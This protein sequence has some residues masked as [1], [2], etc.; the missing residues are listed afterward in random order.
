MVLQSSFDDF[1]FNTLAAVSGLL[2]KLDY[3]AGL[4]EQDGTY[5]HW[6]LARVYGE[7]SAQQTAAEAHRRLFSRV[8]ST[9]LGLLLEDVTGSAKVRD[10]G[11]PSYIDSLAQQVPLLLPD[12]AG[13]AGGLH[14]N[15]VLHALS[16]L[17]RSQKLANPKAS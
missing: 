12:N 7:I 9:P 16:A 8:L 2:R 17:L 14:F 4:R 3:V 5:S 15:S 11:A 1:V 13:R 10:V 6:G